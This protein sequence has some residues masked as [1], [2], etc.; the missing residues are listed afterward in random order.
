[1][2]FV[3]SASPTYF[4]PAALNTLAEDGALVVS[5]FDCQFKRL[6][7]TA[8]SALRRDVEQWGA[9]AMARIRSRVESIGSVA[10]SG[11]TSG[12]P[13]AAVEDDDSVVN[14]VS[15]KV[16]VEVLVGWRAVQASAGNEL[17]FSFEAVDQ[18]EEEF[19]GFINACADAFWA[20]CSPKEA[21][22]LA[23]KS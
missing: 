1:M 9:E 23:A 8:L 5:K 11:Q 13:V 16:L 20:S 3:R 12:V 4:A 6:K 22:H 7:R 10:A 18:T 19:P 15:R 14:M 21:A 17:P 2:S